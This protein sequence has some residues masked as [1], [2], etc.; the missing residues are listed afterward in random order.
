[1]QFLPSS[2]PRLNPHRARNHAVGYDTYRLLYGNG[3]SKKT[4][5]DNSNHDPE[6]ETKDVSKDCTLCNIV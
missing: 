3:D 2:H 5:D 1:M 4:T 6:D